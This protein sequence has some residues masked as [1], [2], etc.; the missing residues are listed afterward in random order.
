VQSAAYVM[1]AL[2]QAD[3]NNLL[4]NYKDLILSI[5]ATVKQ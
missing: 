2:Y 1:Q 4:I 5:A 3:K